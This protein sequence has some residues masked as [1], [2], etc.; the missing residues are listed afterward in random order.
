MTWL[1]S[2]QSAAMNRLS[3]HAAKVDLSNTDEFTFRA[4]LMD[5]IRSEYPKSKLQTEWQRF[6]LLLQVDDYNVLIELKY[7]VY[8]RTLKL[9]GSNGNWKGGAGA[10]NESEFYACVNKLRDTKSR[11]IHEKHLILIYQRQSPQRSPKS[12]DGSYGNL[13]RRHGISQVIEVPH[14]ASERLACID[15]IIE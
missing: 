14:E 10:Q 9:D 2:S 8:R 4:F 1:I 11:S 7:Y 13:Q 12:F 3:A 6:D 15:I 5:A